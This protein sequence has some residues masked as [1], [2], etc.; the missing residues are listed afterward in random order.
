MDQLKGMFLLNVDTVEPLMSHTVACNVCLLISTIA[1]LSLIF[2]HL[3]FFF[4]QSLKSTEEGI[5]R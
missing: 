1:F 2:F 5:S 3:R 4:M